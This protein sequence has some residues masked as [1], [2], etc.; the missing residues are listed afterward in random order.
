MPKNLKLFNGCFIFFFILFLLFNHGSQ[1]LSFHV[2][3]KISQTRHQH[4][5]RR[6][7]KNCTRKSFQSWIVKLTID[8][9]SGYGSQS[10]NH[11]QNWKD[12]SNFV[13]FKRFREKGSNH[14]IFAVAEGVEGADHVELPELVG[15]RHDEQ[16]R[17]L[18]V[19]MADQYRDI[20]DNHE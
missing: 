5:A 18:T 4:H 6:E 13:F 2:D 19:N 3:D 1:V 20:R 16:G 15:E 14:R 8:R 11:C 9:I 10:C 12:F 7:Q 17:G